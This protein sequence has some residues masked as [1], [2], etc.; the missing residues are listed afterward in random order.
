MKKY[1]VENFSIE[2]IECCSAE[3]ASER[4][5][6]WIE[7]YGS[8]KNGYNATRGGDGKHY[9][10][11]DLIVSLFREGKTNRE[12]QK[13]TNYDG[14]TIKKALENGNISSEERILRGIESSYN[15]VAKLDKNTGE[16]LEVYSSVAEATKKNPHTSRHIGQVCKGT[17]KT[18]GGFK[19]K[20]LDK[21]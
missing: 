11:Y 20:Y 5:I 7:Y 2:E 19:W 6:Y 9:A 13:I 8:F 12:I 3:E 16:I 14:A 4:E 1:G 10:D 18:A 21:E 15:P 17:R